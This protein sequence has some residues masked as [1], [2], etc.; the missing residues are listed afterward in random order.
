M[1]IG[2]VNGTMSSPCRAFAAGLTVRF[3]AAPGGCGSRGLASLLFSGLRRPPPRRLFLLGHLP[4]FFLVD[5][6]VV[7]LLL[8]LAVVLV[9]ASFLNHLHL[10]V[11]FFFLLLLLLL[12]FLSLGGPR[13]PALSLDACGGCALL[14]DVVDDPIL[15]LGIAVAVVVRR[16]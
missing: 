13:L 3:A 7:V 8:L 9:G 14:G 16:L 10:A 15:L 2:N 1:S 5:L 12:L 11:V 6:L 4:L